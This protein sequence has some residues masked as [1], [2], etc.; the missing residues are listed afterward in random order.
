MYFLIVSLSRVGKLTD[1][2]QW[3]LKQPNGPNKLMPSWL[4]GF[5]LTGIADSL[6]ADLT[7]E[8]KSILN[9]LQNGNAVNIISDL[10]NIGTNITS[11]QIDNIKKSLTLKPF[12]NEDF[13]ESPEPFPVFME[14]KNKLYN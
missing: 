1:T 8:Q 2:N 6:G 12:I 9:L 11:F 4:Q 10:Q 7:Q 3:H 5:N 14:N 13:Q